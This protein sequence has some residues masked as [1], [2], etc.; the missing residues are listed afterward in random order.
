MKIQWKQLFLCLAVPLI[1]GGLAALLTKNSMTAFEVIRKPALSP[2]GWVFPAVWAV[3]YILM[4]TACYLVIICG[5]PVARSLM[6][7]GIQLMVNF[8]WPIL[9][10][11][12]ELYLLS[13]LCLVLLWIFVLLT[14]WAFSRISKTA[15]YL[16]IP[17]LLWITF[18]GYLNFSIYLLNKG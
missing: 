15:G 11:N 5:K 14:A 7:Y 8:L 12:L 6:L 10:F 3:L 1:I 16:M 4:G 18:A 2:P 17:Y 13:F 9:F